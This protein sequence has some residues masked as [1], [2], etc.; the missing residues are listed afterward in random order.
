MIH[1]TVNKETFQFNY[2]HD[3]ANYLLENKIQEFVTVGIRF[4]READLPL[5]KPLSKF[6]EQE[7]VNLSMESNRHMLQALAKN[8]IAGHIEENSNKW[9]ANTLQVIDKDDVMA[10]DLT[11]AFYVRRKLFTYFLDAYTK[12]VVLQKFIIAEVDV[13]TTQ[14]ELISYNIYLKM[15][16]EKVA[17]M[18]REIAFQREILLEAQALGG[19]GSFSINFKDQEKSIF[20]PEYKKIFEMETVTSFEQFLEWVYPEDRVILASQIE[21]AYKNGGSYEVEYRY[22]KTREKRLWSKGFII[23]EKGKPVFIRGVVRDTTAATP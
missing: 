18:T 12:N 13:Y 2:L 16:Q 1:F 22:K 11:L 9:I 4:S 23:S 14:E 17:V 15:Q 5:L 8:N 7:L 10:E 3:Y 6:S 21:S 19:L 20:T